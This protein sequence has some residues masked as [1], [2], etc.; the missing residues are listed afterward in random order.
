MSRVSL[1]IELD[2]SA[3]LPT[4]FRIFPAGSFETTKG[5]FLFDAQAARKVMAAVADWGND[6][7]IDYGHSMLAFF[8]VDPAKAMKAAGWF[9]PQLKDG[10]LWATDVQWTEDASKMLIAREARYISPAF[11]FDREDRHIT[12]LVNCALTNIPAIKKQMRLVASREGG[13]TYT[14]K[15]QKMSK[16]NR[17]SAWMLYDLGLPPN[18]SP[19][20]VRT[21]LA[22]LK[23]QA[24]AVDATRAK[25]E[26]DARAK[27]EA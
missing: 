27:A 2:V 25:L 4:E 8:N 9:K 22:G 14:R 24:R 11:D 6:Y 21:A 18:A 16:K 23:E 1:S 3:G 17:V 12:E 19:D 15:E 10:E 26:A 5:T 13:P 7:C 20:D